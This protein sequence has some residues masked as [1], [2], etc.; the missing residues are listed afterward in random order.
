MQSINH[1][2]AAYIKKMEDYV[3][4]LL[5]SDNYSDSTQSES[6]ME[7]MEADQFRTMAELLQE[8]IQKM[9]ADA[10]LEQAKK[11][12]KARD[13][14][15]SSNDL[16][17][18][19]PELQTKIADFL[20]AASVKSMRET[21][22]ITK[23]ALDDY[24]AM[25]KALDRTCLKLVKNPT[26][27]QGRTFTNFVCWENSPFR[28]G[29]MNECY[30]NSN[31]CSKVFTEEDVEAYGQPRPDM[32]PRGTVMIGLWAFVGTDITELI[33]PE[34]I[35]N[36]GRHAF[37]G[38]RNLKKI[39]L[40]KTSLKIIQENAFFD[41]GI[42]EI[43]IPKSIEYIGERAFYDSNNMNIVFEGFPP[44]FRMSK[45]VRS[46]KQVTIKADF[47]KGS[48]QLPS[49]LNRWGNPNDIPVVIEPIN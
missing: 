30:Q 17:K 33:L 3:N 37:Q 41:T 36:I 24:H 26:D 29:L 13:D 14:N 44:N 12:K 15:E 28:D 8:N 9:E 39:T 1:L 6:D 20:P 34:G 11:I 47:S 2:L 10:K 35:T 27:Q 43:I 4:N 21:N 18:L 22:S 32:I 45:C 23:R 31:V 49:C 40:P 46:N 38:C 42:E 19:P 5:D 25:Q 7:D 48:F 16:V